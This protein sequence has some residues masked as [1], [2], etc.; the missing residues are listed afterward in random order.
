MI[1]QTLLPIRQPLINN[2]ISKKRGCLR[3]RQPLFLGRNG[4]LSDHKFP[5]FNGSAGF[6][7]NEVDTRSEG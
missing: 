7:L 6:Y 5:G 4:I 3:L 1:R 2:H